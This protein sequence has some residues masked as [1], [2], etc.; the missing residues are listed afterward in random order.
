MGLS[1]APAPRLLSISRS[2]GICTSVGVG[3]GVRPIDDIIKKQFLKKK[4]KCSELV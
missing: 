4:I 1:G 2:C 3:V